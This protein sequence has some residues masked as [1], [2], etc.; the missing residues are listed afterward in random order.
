[1]AFEHMPELADALVHHGSIDLTGRHRAVNHASMRT[2]N[3][4]TD[5]GTGR[6]GPLVCGREL[7]FLHLVRVSIA[8]Y[9]VWLV[10]DQLDSVAAGI[11]A[12]DALAPA[13]SAE[14]IDGAVDDFDTQ[15]QQPLDSLG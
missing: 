9:S 13:V 2:F 11:S 8:G 12:V 3:Q 15:C 5:V 14:P 4:V 10:R 1:M 6:R 7:G